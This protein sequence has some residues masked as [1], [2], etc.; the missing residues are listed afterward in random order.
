MKKITLSIVFI[1]AISVSVFAQKTDEAKDALAVVNK[2]FAEM[3]NHNPA[4]IA[5]LRTKESNLTAVI[6]RKDGKTAVVSFTGEKFSQNF[7]EKKDEI[8]E[9]MY[10][11]KTLVDG[12]VAIAIRHFFMFLL[13]RLITYC[14]RH[15]AVNEGFLLIHIFLDL[16][17]FLGK[18]LRK[19]FARK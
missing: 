17:F 15:V 10:E 14:Y 9:D 4:T 6:K 11:M 16:A 1:L 13:P 2:M 7:A 5:E 3:A 18:I 8:K 19:F 12:D